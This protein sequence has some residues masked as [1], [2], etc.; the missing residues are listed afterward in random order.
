MVE[1]VSNFIADGS[2]W[3]FPWEDTVR[4][5]EIVDDISAH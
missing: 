4:V 1:N 3:V 5:A 2:G